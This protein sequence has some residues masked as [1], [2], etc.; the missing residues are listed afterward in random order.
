MAARRPCSAEPAATSATPLIARS[1]LRGRCPTLF[2]QKL[3]QQFPHLL[4]GLLFRKGLLSR[5]EP[6][7][8]DFPLTLP[9]EFRFGSGF[10]VGSGVSVGVDSTMASSTVVIFP[11]LASAFLWSL[12]C[13][14]ATTPYRTTVV[15]E[16]ARPTKHCDS[17][18]FWP[19]V[20]RLSWIGL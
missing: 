19:R 17:P 7:W 4:L 8:L 3:P 2:R 11:C 6:G 1:P 18:I 10:S 12:V 16:W 5:W 20:S 15:H 9:M 13:G 14:E